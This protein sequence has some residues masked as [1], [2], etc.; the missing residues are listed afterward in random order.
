MN[1]SCIL[2]FTLVKALSITG[3]SEHRHKHCSSLLHNRETASPRGD[4]KTSCRS[5]TCIH[6]ETQTWAFWSYSHNSY[7]W[8]GPLVRSHKPRD[9]QLLLAWI[10]YLPWSHRL[11]YLTGD[12]FW[13][14]QLNTLLHML[15]ITK[16]HYL[17][18]N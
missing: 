16:S 7:R 17:R 14:R 12:H 1:T 5:S 8:F 15:H 9:I 6:N 10:M 2:P 13:V 11:W 3:H 4:I 18:F